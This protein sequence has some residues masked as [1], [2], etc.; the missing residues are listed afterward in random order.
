[1]LLNRYR[2]WKYTLTAAPLGRA[3][4]GDVRPA[5]RLARARGRLRLLRRGLSDLAY[6]FRL[7]RVVLF[8]QFAF[9]FALASPSFDPAR[10]WLLGLAILCLGP[11]L[12]G[13]LYALNDVA[14][15]A[16]DRQHPAKRR[17]PVASGRISLPVARGLGAALVAVGLGL[18]LALD[19]RVFALGL[20]FTALNL[21]YT[22]VF[23]HVRGLDLVFN[24][25]THPLRVAGGLW[26]GGDL[27]HWPLLVVW[28]LGGLANCAVKRLF[29]LRTAPA[30]SRPILRGY[31]EP[32]LLRFIAVCLGAGLGLLPFLSGVHFV[33]ASAVLVYAAALVAGYRLPGAKRIVQL[34][35]R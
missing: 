35:G 3:W 34:L 6:L 11:C 2:R 19:L 4:R 33:I 26:L 29:E 10:L 31:T 15:A 9:G 28:A 30:A 22:H 12:Y 25:A 1:M 32:S 8:G 20:A 5:R 21:L 23:K 24:M 7:E 17:R 27:S 14:D 18:G 16:A 13:G